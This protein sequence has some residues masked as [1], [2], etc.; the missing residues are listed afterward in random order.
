MT[1]TVGD[2]LREARNKK[3]LALQTIE[4]ST[5]IATHNLLAIELDQ[6][7]LIDQDKLE[8]FLETYAKEVDIPYASL[9]AAPGFPELSAPAVASTPEQQPLPTPSVSVEQPAQPQPA[10]TLSNRVE[11]EKTV[12]VPTPVAPSNLRRTSGRTKSG[13]EKSG[14]FFKVV[15]SLLLTA[16]IIFAGFTVYKQYFANSSAKTSKTEKP[17]SSSSSTSSSST[18]PA[19]SKPAEPTPTTKLAVTGGGDGINVA[20]T[21]SQKPVKIE[22][23][24]AG[25]GA[26][27]IGVSNSDIGGVTLNAETPKATAILNEG[28]TQSLIELGVTQGVT[29]KINDQVLD[30]S[31]ITNTA[32]SSVSLSIQ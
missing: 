19:S 21:T 16:A 32:T 18:T 8:A 28:A 24:Y 2:L 14:G 9:K 4:R 13:K 5:G 29:I 7:S 12:A 6:F 15:V 3:G 10:P 25:S 26:S 22:L 27:W 17:S 30:M 11:E 23:S 20:V 1:K 31:A